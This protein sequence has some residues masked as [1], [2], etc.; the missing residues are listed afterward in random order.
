[1][2]RHVREEIVDVIGR[3]LGAGESL[4]EC[5]PVWATE[6]GGRTPLLLRGRILHFL[7]LTDQRLVL[8]RAP[9]WRRRL[10]GDDLVL[11][12]R[13]SS[14]ELERVRTRLP[15]LQV[16]VSAPGSRRLV[17]EFRPRQ[18]ALGRALVRALTPH[19]EPAAVAR[20]A[21]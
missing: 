7:A 1:M 5:G 3:A 14:F 17:F 4:R 21:E 13:L 16:V 10:D 18:R 6:L 2:R 9:R 19:E 8:F 12:K 20:A 11:A 15:M